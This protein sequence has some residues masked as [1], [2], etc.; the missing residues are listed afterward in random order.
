MGDVKTTTTTPGLR[1]RCPDE[2][3]SF[4][5]TPRDFP[6]IGYCMEIS[7]VYTDQVVSFPLLDIS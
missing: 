3:G 4:S 2:F 7:H 6:T 1:N 5:E